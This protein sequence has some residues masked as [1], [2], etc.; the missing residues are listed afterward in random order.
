[1]KRVQLAQQLHGQSSIPRDVQAKAQDAGLVILVGPFA[2]FTGAIEG[3]AQPPGIDG[4]SSS[5]VYFDA[6]GILPHEPDS[7]SAA[8]ERDFYNRKRLAVAVDVNHK[9]GGKY[10]WS[11]TAPFVHSTFDL[12][13]DE[14]PV[15]RGIV[16]ALVDAGI[17]AAG[18]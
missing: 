17:D 13:D 12:C 10:D 9:R 8:A 2:R 15:C 4:E 14:R 16:F 1:M 11:Y 7:T 3:E 5:P 6:K 18:V